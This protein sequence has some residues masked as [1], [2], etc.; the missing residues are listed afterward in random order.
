LGCILTAVI[1]YETVSLNNKSHPVFAAMFMVVAGALYAAV[2][3]MTAFATGN[4]QWGCQTA[5]GVACLAFDS[6]S[7][8]FFQYGIAL[9]VTLPFIMGKGSLNSLK[10]N[11]FGLHLLRVTAAV[12]GVELWVAGFARGVPLWTMVALLMTSPLFVII[13]SALILKE[14]VSALRVT[15]TVLG[16]MGAVIILEP[17]HGF[18]F[19]LIF[20]IAASLGWAM[21]S[22]CVKLLANED[23]AETITLWLLIL[24]T[25]LALIA[26]FIY[27]DLSGAT[28][29]FWGIGQGPVMPDEWSLVALLLAAGFLSAMAQLCLAWSY[30][31]GDASYVQPFD[32]VKLVF[33]IVLS[34]WLFQDTPQGILWVGILMII[35][36][37]L[38]IGWREYRAHLNGGVA[39]E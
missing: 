19:N 12:I 6:R 37:S 11:L 27:P 31:W 20:P 24:F 7:Y 2:N 30:K 33:N 36:A 22:L 15:A 17:W 5:L 38:F 13:G 9:L 18:D 39:T 1:R 21:A 10:T 23:S 32:H 34:W 35:G 25:P 3:S 16:L 26:T 8:T 4:P 14:Q 29:Q 28:E